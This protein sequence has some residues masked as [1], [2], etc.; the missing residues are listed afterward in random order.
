LSRVAPPEIDPW[1]MWREHRR[2][3]A[4]HGPL[5]LDTPARYIATQNAQIGVLW[6]EAADHDQVQGEQAFPPMTTSGPAVRCGRTPG[7]AVCEEV[8][9]APRVTTDITSPAVSGERPSTCCK[10][11]RG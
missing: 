11:Q 5:P 9:H 10:Q 6:V 7:P 4:D 8:T 2:L 3:Q 1:G